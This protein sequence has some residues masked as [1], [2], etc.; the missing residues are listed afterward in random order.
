MHVLVHMLHKHLTLHGM[1]TVQVLVDLLLWM[2]SQYN[3]LFFTVDVV[4]EHML[5][6]V[7]GGKWGQHSH[8]MLVW[9]SSMLD[10]DIH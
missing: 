9:V 10:Q 7:V 4:T 3:C 8:C 5:F 1:L 6:T 2:L